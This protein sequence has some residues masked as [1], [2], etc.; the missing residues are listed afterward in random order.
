LLFWSAVFSTMTVRPALE[1]SSATTLW[2]RAHCSAWAP[3]GVSQRICQSPWTDRT[4]PWALAAA[5][6]PSKAAATRLAPIQ[7]RTAADHREA[8]AV[9]G[10]FRLFEGPIGVDPSSIPFA[11]FRRLLCWPVSRPVS[12]ANIGLIRQ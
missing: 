7:Q 9:V 2:I 6:R 10:L 3:G 12:D 1:R 4:A 11:S 5:V 8:A